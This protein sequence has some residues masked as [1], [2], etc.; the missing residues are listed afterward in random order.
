MQSN[1]RKSF[2]KTDDRGVK[3]WKWKPKGVA[4]LASKKKTKHYSIFEHS[5]RIIPL[6]ADSQGE[7]AKDMICFINYLWAFKDESG[8]EIGWTTDE[9]RIRAKK[10]FLDTLSATFAKARIT[11]MKNMLRGRHTRGAMNNL[12]RD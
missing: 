1:Q 2:Y 12:R 7:L 6:A 10:S 3:T 8:D 9:H 11:D 5:G 4:E